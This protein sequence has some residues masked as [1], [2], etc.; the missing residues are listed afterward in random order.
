MEHDKLVLCYTDVVNRFNKA[1]N[2]IKAL[3]V[4]VKQAQSNTDTTEITNMQ[5]SQALKTAESKTMEETK[6]LS[7]RIEDLTSKYL[8]AEKQVRTLKAKIKDSGGKERRRSS[9]GIRQDELLVHREAESVLEDIE[10]SLNHIEGYVKGGKDVVK[11]ARKKSYEIST[12]ASRARRRSSETSDVSFVER[13]KKT[14]KSIRKLVNISKMI[15]SYSLCL[16]L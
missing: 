10:S 6:L 4:S 2:E 7:C 14:E 15:N 13:L 12:K 16:S 1:I 3:K 9:T 11:D 8:T 5:L